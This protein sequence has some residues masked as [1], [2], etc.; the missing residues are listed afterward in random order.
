[1]AYKIHIQVIIQV[2]HLLTLRLVT[3][4]M[5]YQFS[6]MHTAAMLDYECLNCCWVTAHM[7]DETIVVENIHSQVSILK[8]QKVMANLQFTSSYIWRPCWF[9]IFGGRWEYFTILFE[10]L[11]DENVGIDTKNQVSG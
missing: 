6:A 2:R 9:S 7:L 10:I 5:T 4:V 1:M 8:N 3:L 11:T